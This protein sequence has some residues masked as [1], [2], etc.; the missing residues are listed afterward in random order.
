MFFGLEFMPYESTD[1]SDHLICDNCKYDLHGLADLRCPECGEEFDLT[2]QSDLRNQKRNNWYTA[3][4][5]LFSLW[6]GSISLVMLGSHPPRDIYIYLMQIIPLMIAFVLWIRVVRNPS[7]IQIFM[8]TLALPC[9][10]FSV[11]A[12]FKVLSYWY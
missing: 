11:Y 9:L 2:G 7:N 3:V 5:F 8:L 6:S 12:W 1:E 4:A 10:Y